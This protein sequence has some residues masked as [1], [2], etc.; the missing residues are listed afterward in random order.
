VRD[1]DAPLV[2]VRLAASTQLA[3]TSQRR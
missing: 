2:S 1:L 3:R